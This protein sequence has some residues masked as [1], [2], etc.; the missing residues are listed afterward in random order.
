MK[1]KRT[2]NGEEYEFELT[3]EE[4]QDTY[5]EKKHMFDLCDTQMVL[6]QTNED[7]ILD[8]PTAKRDAVVELIARRYRERM[9]NDDTWYCTM[10]DV[11]ADVAEEERAKIKEYSLPVCRVNS[12]VAKVKAP[13]LDAAIIMVA[14]GEVE[15]KQIEDVDGESWGLSFCADEI[16]KEDYPDEFENLG[17][18]ARKWL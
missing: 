4:A 3:N 2:I 13:S 8:L 17:E 11:I 6:E 7:W 10:K 9:D 12:G 18:E 15:D 1:I 16:L 14:K 5:Y